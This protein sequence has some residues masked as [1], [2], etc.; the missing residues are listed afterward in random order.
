[1]YYK[2]SRVYVINKYVNEKGKKVK[3][4]SKYCT[5]RIIKIKK[6]I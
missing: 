6:D 5:R 2:Q 1:M 4:Y 3:S